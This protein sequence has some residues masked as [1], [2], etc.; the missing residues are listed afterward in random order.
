MEGSAAVERKDERVRGGER[1]ASEREGNEGK[2]MRGR[3]KNLGARGEEAPVGG[4]TGER[5][6]EIRERVR[7]GLSYYQ[8]NILSTLQFHYETASQNTKLG[9]HCFRL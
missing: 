2:E 1:R 7:R 5:E 9:Q 3:E 6:R 8:A 4:G